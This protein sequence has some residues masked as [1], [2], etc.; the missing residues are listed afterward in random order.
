LGTPSYFRTNH[1]RS[2]SICPS[3]ASHY[4]L[5]MVFSPIR[6]RT[7]RCVSNN[8]VISTLDGVLNWGGGGPLMEEHMEGMDLKALNGQRITTFSFYKLRDTA[9]H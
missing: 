7:A 4:R 1:Q 9:A 6:G 5:K 8:T 2:I 3:S